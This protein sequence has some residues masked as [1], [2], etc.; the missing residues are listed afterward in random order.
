MSTYL[1]DPLPD[2]AILAVGQKYIGGARWGG[3]ELA[4]PDSSVRDA[5]GD[6][7]CDV[8][9]LPYTGSDLVAFHIEPEVSGVTVKA[10]RDRFRTL[11]ATHAS[12][13]GHTGG[14]PGSSLG[15]SAGL[16]ET[17]DQWSAFWGW[18]KNWGPLLLGGAAV[19]VAIY[20]GMKAR[21]G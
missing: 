17:G 4:P 7:G 2:T 13:W 16:Q 8:S 15:G 12:V 20:F 11:K 5:L 18:A 19:G 9:T 6:L 3:A 1:G 21:K 14:I 10:V